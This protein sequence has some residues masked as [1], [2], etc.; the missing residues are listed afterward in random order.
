[1][2]EN[3]FPSPFVACVASPSAIYANNREVRDS[4]LESLNKKHYQL[5]RER[6]KKLVSWSSRHF[7]TKRS[8]QITHQTA[9]R[10]DISILTDV[11]KCMSFPVAPTVGG[12]QSKK[13]EDDLRS[14]G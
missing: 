9:Y 14:V 10:T 8:Q 12:A 2:L 4:Y 7:T 11:A 3:E 6:G 5:Q 1:M 13:I